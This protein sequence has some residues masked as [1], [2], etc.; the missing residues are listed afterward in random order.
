MKIKIRSAFSLHDQNA[1][2]EAIR[3]LLD[4][5]DAR[6]ADMKDC[7]DEIIAGI[8]KE[9]N[10][11]VL[12]FIWTK[13]ATMAPDEKIRSFAEQE[14]DNSS[15]EN[16]R[17]ALAYLATVYPEESRRLYEKM[18]KDNNAFVLFEAGKAILP[19]DQKLALNLW[20]SIIGISPHVLG[21]EIIPEYIA[22]YAD[23][24]F[25]SYLEKL[26]EENP[27]D[28]ITEMVLEV[29]KQDGR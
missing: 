17:F 13:L 5:I 15:P 24:E 29:I 16:R 18:Q 3:E 4:L 23:A 25:I 1:K 2:I 21:D 27:N 28:K 20:F 8:E 14:L 19:I 26:Y 9:I 7:V 11:G 22:Q 10:S 6:E 12:S